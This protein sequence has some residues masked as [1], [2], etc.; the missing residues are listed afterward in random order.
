M[1]NIFLITPWYDFDNH[2]LFWPN[3]LKVYACIFLSFKIFSVY[4]S[5]QQTFSDPIF[6]QMF[7]TQ[8]FFLILF[9]ALL[10]F[11]HTFQI[12][13]NAFFFQKKWKTML[14]NFEYIDGK[15]NNKNSIK[16]N[17]YGNFY[18]HLVIGH[19]MFIC[20]FGWYV[21]IWILISDE[22]EKIMVLLSGVDLYN[23]FLLVIFLRCLV[24]CF[25]ERYRDLGSDLAFGSSKGQDL[26]AHLRK[27]KKILRLLKENVE[28][29]NETF[30]YLLLL[31][32]INCGFDIVQCG[33]FVF[34]N[35]SVF[36]DVE[37]HGAIFNLITISLFS[38]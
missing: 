14:K 11:Q 35:V 26:I 21:Y 34:V 17:I 12:I 36:K 22:N 2:A 38:V 3:L 23:Q 33:N 24:K 29:F 30:G 28:L 4:V 20:F 25:V 15:L 13:S 8:Q 6:Q 1:T 16:T 7:I 19:I 27:I 9:Y 31:I 32:L 5:L 10:L 18:F 37:L